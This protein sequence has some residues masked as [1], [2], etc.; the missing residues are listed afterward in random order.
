ML[1]E[2]GTAAPSDEDGYEWDSLV[3]DASTTERETG[4][5]HDGKF[6]RFRASPS[7]GRS[8]ALGLQ[9]GDADD[10]A[11]TESSGCT[12]NSIERDGNVLRIEQT[13]EL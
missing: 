7:Y 11:L 6:L 4:W 2:S 13:I 5:G 9:V 10:H 8:R 1:F 12:G 3:L